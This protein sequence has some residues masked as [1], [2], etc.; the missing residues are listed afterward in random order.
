MQF[1]VFFFAFLHN[2]VKSLSSLSLSHTK[3]KQTFFRLSLSSEIAKRNQQKAELLYSFIDSPGSIYV[4]VY[5]DLT[6]LEH[7][8]FCD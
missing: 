7:L 1:F 5:K 4:Y 8:S 6:V 3:Y 2:H